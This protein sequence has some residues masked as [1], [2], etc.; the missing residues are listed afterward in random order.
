MT[1]D[2]ID[3]LNTVQEVL[4]GMLLAIGTISP[5]ALPGIAQGLRAS[6]MHPGASPMA[7]T[8]LADLASGMEMLASARQRKQ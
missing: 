3:T 4:R 2:Q 8:M 1:Q 5:P 6:S 7:S